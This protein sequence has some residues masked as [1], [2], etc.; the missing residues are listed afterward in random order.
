M[1]GKIVTDMVDRRR[2]GGREMG[3]GRDRERE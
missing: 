3:D 1:R 2:G